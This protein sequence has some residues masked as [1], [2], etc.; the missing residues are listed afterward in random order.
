MKPICIISAR[1][2]SKGI[3]NKNIRVMGDKPLIAHTIESAVRSGIFQHVF[4]STDSLEIAEISKQYGAQVPF[5]RP[6]ELSTDVAN[7]VDVL[8]HVIKKLY[9]LNYEFE[10]VVM[11]DCTVPFI[12]KDDIHG[13]IDLFNKSDCDT[14]YAA[15][16]AHPNPYFGMAEL[17]A[18]GYLELSKTTKKQIIRRQDAPIVYDL[19]G[20]IVFN[21][22][23]FLKIGKLFTI[24]ALP[25]EI[26]KENGHMIDFEFDFKVAEL[27]YNNRK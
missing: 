24:K 3:P 27:L 15:I 7:M 6:K 9:S 18:A 21:A 17:N 22:K 10:I 14:V 2:G 1:E 13:A 16:K 26:T 4:V 11:R 23:K 19:D 20:M 25:Y 8:I 5:I 12:D